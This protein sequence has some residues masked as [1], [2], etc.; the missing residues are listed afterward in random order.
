MG[1]NGVNELNYSI[2]GRIM[3]EPTS[4][5]SLGIETGYFLLYTANYEKG[6]NTVHI[7]N[8]IVP[9][10]IRVDG[11]IPKTRTY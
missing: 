2:S 1:K 7:S 6:A 11:S 10:H 4:L 5:L 3:W 8:A 9:I